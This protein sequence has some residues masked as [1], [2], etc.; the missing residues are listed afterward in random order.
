MEIIESR[1]NERFNTNAKALVKREASV[2]V[3][4]KGEQYRNDTLKQK[5]IGNIIFSQCCFCSTVLQSVT[6]IFRVYGAK[7][8]T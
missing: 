8:M 7:G 5:L 4:A 6:Y 3:L 2:N 1:I